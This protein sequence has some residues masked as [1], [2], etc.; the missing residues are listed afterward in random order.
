VAQPLLP[1]GHAAA[2]EA[3]PAPVSR[4]AGEDAR[5]GEALC[6]LVLRI[7]KATLTKNFDAIT[8]MDPYATVSF[9][10]AD[11]S[12]WEASRTRVDRG[13]HMSPEWDHTCC[14][15]P[16]CK[17]DTVEIEVWEKDMVFDDFCG[18]ACVPV[19]EL[20]SEAKASASTTFAA[21]N[22][23][24]LPLKLEDGE[25]TGTISIQALVMSAEEEKGHSDDT[26]TS[27][28]PALFH[29]P[30]ARLGVSGG[31]APFFDLRLKQPSGTLENHF[32]GKDL[33]HAHDEF[34]FYEE[35]LALK[36][37]PGKDVAM[38]DLLGFALD[39]AGVAR[40]PVQGGKGRG[41]D[42]NIDLLVMRNMRAGFT[43]LRLLDIKIGQV[44]AQ[45][46]WQ[47]KSRL[48]ALRNSVVDG[49]TNSQAEGFRLEG[50]DHRPPG[51]ASMDPLLD[52]GGCEKRKEKTV[53]KANRVMLQRFSGAEM[54]AH[55]LDVHQ[56][57]NG[58]GEADVS[59][60]FSPIEVAEIACH[61]VVFRLANLALAC[62]RSPVPHKWIGS[63][64]ALGFD[65]GRLPR[66][67]EGAKAVR[68]FTVVNIFDWGRS[69]LNT[70]EKHMRLSADDQHDRSK[71]WKFYMGGIDR[72]FWE[73]CRA[74][75]HMFGNAGEWKEITLTLY[76]FDSMSRNDFIGKVTVPLQETPETTET[77]TFSSRLAGTT[78]CSIT[79]SV[80]WRPLP[81]GSRL[82]GSWRVSIFRGSNMPDMDVMHRL[83]L[84]SS[85]KQADPF[86]EVVA[87]SATRS[88]QL[89]Q[90]TTVKVDCADPEWNEVFD[91]PV[92]TR[93]GE[94]Q[95]ALKAVA[96]GLGSTEALEALPADCDSQRHRIDED[97]ALWKAHL[98]SCIGM[99]AATPNHLFG[100]DGDDSRGW[101]DD[102]GKGTGFFIEEAN[103]RTVCCLLPC[104]GGSG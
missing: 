91:I 64:V 2:E 67:T 49:I 28:D 34:S 75:K 63:S 30:V 29:T 58:L 13:G 80:A 22:V 46:G 47:G 81:K 96:K 92:A 99:E 89:R 93:E 37:H 7:F 97:I 16:F 66:R 5:R 21:G 20:M 6:V 1:S 36:K 84:F 90:C 11:G 44:T 76:D 15:Q 53:K 51:L 26:V 71:F 73:A 57:S 31:T 33:S 72:L 56:P 102:S 17:G 98:D 43:E 69:E 32:I 48:G 79:Y 12:R 55:F 54:L 35:M 85:R 8:K 86:I 45:A 41:G 39:Y 42:P 78:H 88:F 19:E 82:K 87:T 59:S 25:H 68:K 60:V 62:R 3:K 14:K 38:V 40:L 23:I 103:N 50:F 94:L 83:G 27:V 101:V 100:D 18:K 52:V 95:G 65:A 77:L 10:A 74:Y 104:I 4:P 61:E 9:R 24:E 70:L